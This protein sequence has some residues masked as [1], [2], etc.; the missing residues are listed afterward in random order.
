MGGFDSIE[1]VSRALENLLTDALRELGGSRPPVA[2]LHSL[3]PPPSR[4]PPVLSLFLY[5]ISEDPTVRN[6]PEQ[7]TVEVDAQGQ[8][9]YRTV[10]PPM[11]LLLRY[12][13]TPWATTPETELLMIGRTMQVLYERQVRRGAE[14]TPEP[15]LDAVSITLAPLSLDER[16]RVW[17]AIQEPYKLSLN[18]EARVVDIDVRPESGALHPPVRR[19]EFGQ[20]V[21]EGTS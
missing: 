17:W 19:R 14:L 15:D 6:R 1:R 13:I 2:Q 20:T 16:S 18:Y 9:L 10:K 4:Q 11:A 21:P 12:L 7:R 5:E 3:K 8:T